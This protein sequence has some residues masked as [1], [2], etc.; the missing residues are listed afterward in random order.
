MK[1]TEEELQ[2]E[3]NEMIKDF[4][5]TIYCLHKKGYEKLRFLSYMSAS[6]CWYNIDLAP[7][8]CFYNNGEIRFIEKDDLVLYYSDSEERRYFWWNN[9]K[10]LSPNE[11]AEKI[12][13]KCPKLAKE[14]FGK[15]EEYALWYKDLMEKIEQNI[16]PLVFEEFFSA[17][18]AGHLGT[19]GGDAYIPLP[20]PGDFDPKSI[21]YDD[22]NVPEEL[23]KYQKFTA[24]DWRR[25]S[26]EEIKEMFKIRKKYGLN[27]KQLRKWINEDR[28]Q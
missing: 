3:W 26:E 25:T 23:K 15:D 10:N 22:F 8:S 6:G 14:S 13:K 4:F 17:E 24:Q 27:C 11:L 5:R 18:E 28:K 7:K 12:I 2:I 20:P 9:V 1:K 16:F 21:I 19:I